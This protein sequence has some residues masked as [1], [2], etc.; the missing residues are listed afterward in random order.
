MR[1]FRR[2]A[3]QHP[4]SVA[5]RDLARRLAAL[6]EEDLALAEVRGLHVCVRDGEVTL[7]GSVPHPLDRD[8]LVRVV[9][10]QPGVVRVVNRLRLPGEPEPDDG[11]AGAS[12]RG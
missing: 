8:T 6:L 7:Q 12:P 11:S 3:T 9:A 2:T 10:C 1:L 5:D 4:E